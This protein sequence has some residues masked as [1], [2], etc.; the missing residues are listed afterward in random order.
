[1][2][3][4]T[5][6][7]FPSIYAPVWI[8]PGSV[9]SAVQDLSSHMVPYSSTLPV[10]TFA[11]PTATGI[12]SAFSSSQSAAKQASTRN[13]SSSFEK[14]LPKWQLSHFDG[15]PLEWPE[16][17]GMFLSTAH[18]ANISDAEK[19]NPLKTL[20]QGKA[21]TAIAGYTFS[22]KLYQK[23]RETLE[24][25]FGQPHVIVGAQ[26]AKLSS[27]P[28][29][30]MHDSKSVIE[31]AMIVTTFVNVLQ[32]LGF[33][34][35]LD[36]AS[37]L[38]TVVLKFPPNLREKWRSYVLESNTS[39]PTLRVFDPWLQ[40]IA[41]THERMLS[42]QSLGSPKDDKAWSTRKDKDPGQV[43][44]NTTNTSPT[45]KTVPE[46]GV[47]KPPVGVQRKP[48]SLG[49]GNHDLTHCPAFKKLT[50]DDRALKV[51]ELGLCFKCILNC[52]KATMCD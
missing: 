4:Y 7:A 28:S 16:W 25:R 39:R 21:I 45:V 23:A 41:D 9:S 18:R 3:S 15:N 33:D 20:L 32:E 51:K 34:G 24:R 40:S 36:S 37:N 6:A 48:C 47:T 17:R 1:M 27:Y 46:T 44:S 5:D 43:T 10:T 12:E 35:D 31:Y 30:R 8:P 49:D 50:V 19:M 26:L 13:F 22:E 14:S 2:G 38:N 29:V 52:H 11:T 42:T